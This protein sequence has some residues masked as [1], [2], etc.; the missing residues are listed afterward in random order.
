[1]ILAGTAVAV[2]GN[3]LAGWSSFFEKKKK[4]KKKKPRCRM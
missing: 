1:V 4:N 2:A 3:C